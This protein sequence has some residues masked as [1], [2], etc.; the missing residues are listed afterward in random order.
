M[1]P[2]KPKS[3]ESVSQMGDEKQIAWFKSPPHPSVSL[4]LFPDLLT[5]PP[6]FILCVPVLG[7]FSCIRLCD[8]MNYRLPGSSVRGILQ[9]RILEWVAVPSSRGSSR[10]RNGTSVSYVS[11]SG[12]FFYLWHYLGIRKIE[13]ATKVLTDST[14]LTSYIFPCFQTSVFSKVSSIMTKRLVLL[15]E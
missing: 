13:I 14:F 5:Q 10:P 11:F 9:A 4:C 1:G 3:N 8:P 12:R 7:C 2:I 15:Y 6:Q